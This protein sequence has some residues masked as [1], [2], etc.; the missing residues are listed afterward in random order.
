MSINVYIVDDHQ[1]FIDGLKLIL[2]LSP[3]INVVGFSTEGQKCL[4]ELE[5]LDV[6]V[7]LTDISMPEMSGV[8][9]TKRVVEKFPLIKILTLSM[10]QDYSY[11][12]AMMKAGATG[13]ILKNTGAKELLEAIKEVAIGN[14][15]YSEK[16]K[17]AI[18][19]GFAADKENKI[20]FNETLL[21]DVQITPREREIIRL[22]IV[23]HN[24][25]E[26]AEMLDLSVHTI[27]AHRKNINAKFNVTCLNELIVVLK[28]LDLGFVFQR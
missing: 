9:L 14:K 1:M 10:H 24:S 16:V 27:S 26:I 7:L 20:D 28:K 19:Q 5:S 3:E 22:L 2:N 17:D 18:I 12:N 21:K 23:G 15:F 6:N 13:Y 25:N 4:F 11:I 8:E